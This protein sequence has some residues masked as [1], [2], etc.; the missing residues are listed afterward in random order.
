MEVKKMELKKCYTCSEEKPVSMYNKNANCKDGLQPSCKA[1]QSIY[2][3]RYGEIR[4]APLKAATA[5]KKLEHD[6][7]WRMWKQ[8]QVMSIRRKHRRD[9]LITADE[10]KHFWNTTDDKCY[11]CGMT[12]E[13]FKEIRDGI[14]AYTGDNKII[15]KYKRFP[16]SRIAR[17]T[18]DR[19]DNNRG[20]EIGNLRK[21]CYICNSIKSNML[22]ADE[23]KLFA[24]DIMIELLI[25]LDEVKDGK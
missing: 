12:T 8:I 15:N 11:Y 19:M 10:F 4:R 16:I 1:C 17:L 25:S 3:K 21:A 24:E 7:L 22:T 14:K 20:Y 6:G 13:T 18:V 5:K 23:M 9:F 2:N